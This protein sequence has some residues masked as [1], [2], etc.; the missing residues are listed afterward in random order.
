MGLSKDDFFNLMIVTVGYH[1]SRYI[2]V[3]GGG[4]FV[5]E[6]IREAI[7]ELGLIE[8]YNELNLK[9]SSQHKGVKKM[10]HHCKLN[11]ISITGHEIKSLFRT[12]K[13]SQNSKDLIFCTYNVGSVLK[14][15]TD[16]FGNRYSFNHYYDYLPDYY[17]EIKSYNSNMKEISAKKNIVFKNGTRIESTLDELQTQ[18]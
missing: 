4:Y 2:R 6:K 18:I 7:I 11:N 8:K 15:L 16:I 17:R 13:R 3:D 10:I 9:G 14:A 5:N 12:R 1:N